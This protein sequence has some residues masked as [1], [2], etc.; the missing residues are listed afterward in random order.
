MSI[1]YYLEIIIPTQTAVKPNTILNATYEKEYK[2][3]L[4]ETKDNDSKEKVENVVKPPQ[5]PTINKAFNLGG[6]TP[7]LFKNPYNIPKIRHPKILI[8]KVAKGQDDFKVARK[9]LLTK[10]L[11]QVPIK[12]PAPAISINFHITK[13]K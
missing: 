5:K 11:Q 12:P 3:S 7:D 9:N 6:I 4:L 2:N 10:N 13:Q 8:V 1:F